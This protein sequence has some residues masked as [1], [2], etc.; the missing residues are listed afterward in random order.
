MTDDDKFV[1]LAPEHA[2]QYERFTGKPYDAARLRMWHNW[3]AH[4]IRNKEAM[5]AADAAAGR[6]KGR[7]ELVIAE[8]DPPRPQPPTCKVRKLR[9]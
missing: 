2:Q 4:K 3:V 1:P 9:G 5:D 6:V 7:V 8:P